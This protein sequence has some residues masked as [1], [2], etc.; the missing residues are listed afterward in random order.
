MI[1]KSLRGFVE[2]I[3]GVAVP[4]KVNKRPARPNS[5]KSISGPGAGALMILFSFLLALR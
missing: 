5:S 3:G 2:R 4:F 1:S